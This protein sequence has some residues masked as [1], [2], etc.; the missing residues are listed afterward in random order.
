MKEQLKNWIYTVQAFAWVIAVSSVTFGSALAWHEGKG[1]AWYYFLTLIAGV[2]MQCGVNSFNAYDNFVKGIEA[3]KTSH[4]ASVSPLV[5]GLIK[6]DD[7]KTLGYSAFT[8]ASLIGFYLAYK[9]GWPVLVFGA[10]GL[11]G[12]RN[13]TG[14]RFSYKYL[15]LGPIFV[16]FLMGTFMVLPSYFI[17]SGHYEWWPALASVPISLLISMVMHANDIRD[18]EDD[19]K[20]NT[21]TIATRLGRKKALVL[22]CLFWIAAYAVQFWCIKLGYLPYTTLITALLIP[23]LIKMMRTHFDESVSRTEVISLEII[24]ARLMLFYGILNV[25]A[26]VWPL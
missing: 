11:F 2:L 23:V 13:Y 15:G 7:V 19:R 22:Y 17:Q 1:N 9:C 25:I 20:T 14:G 10:I 4:G 12:G 3:Q 8:V 24:S 21:V 6:A 16:F 18:I 5:R 26:L